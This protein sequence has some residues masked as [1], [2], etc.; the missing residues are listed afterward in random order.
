MRHFVESIS[1]YSK[2]LFVLIASIFLLACNEPKKDRIPVIVFTDLY[3]PGQDLGDNFDILTPYALPE[4]DLRGIIFDVT[5]R[6]RKDTSNLYPVFREPGFIPATQLNYIFDRNIPM[7]C[8]P[9]Q[10]MKNET[11]K[12]EDIPAFQQQGIDL[13]LR[14]LQE[15]KEKV[16]VVST[17]SARGLAV[18]YNRDPELMKQKIS[19]IHFC[20][21]SSSDKFR[22][23]NIELD[24]L[25]AFRLLSSDLPIAIY[26]CATENG[27]FDKGQNNT[28]WALDSLNFILDMDVP[29]KKYLLFSLLYKDR[30][31]F[32]SY[33]ETEVSSSE[34]EALKTRSKGKWYGDE[35]RHYV[36]ETA[37]WQQVSKRKLV[38]RNGEEAHILPLKEIKESDV[39]FDESLRPCKVKVDRSGLFSSEYTNENTNFSIYYRENPEQN[40]VW[41]KEALPNL[42]RSF[43]SNK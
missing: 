13:F 5:D 43:K 28:F 18:A 4:L 15:S 9:F 22:E 27:P 35:P 40:E 38:K 3:F 21:G 29:L 39:V 8:T 30:T 25:A 6:Y 41:L 12:M 10:S 26:P 14:L 33:L 32:L 31:D 34:I 16:E 36:W 19:R 1:G 37:V 42:Y 24:T 11:D 2:Q 17:G 23:W 7:A 20:A